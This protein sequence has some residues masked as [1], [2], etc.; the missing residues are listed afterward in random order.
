MNSS[1]DNYKYESD[2]TEDKLHMLWM[3]VEEKWPEIYRQFTNP[4]YADPD[5]D[6]TDLR[7]DFGIHDVVREAY[8]HLPHYP[9]QISIYADMKR[10]LGF[11]LTPSSLKGEY[12]G[13]RR[14]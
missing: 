12:R 9:D 2:V 3:R 11:Y 10:F 4:N 7:L 1:A 13:I 6:D 14:D 8:P 5:H